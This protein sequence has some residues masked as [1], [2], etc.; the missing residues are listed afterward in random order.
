MT[1]QSKPN[2]VSLEHDS[3]EQNKHSLF[4]A[5]L[6]RAKYL[7]PNPVT[8][9]QVLHLEARGHRLELKEHDSSEPLLFRVNPVSSE[10]NSSERNKPSLF[11]A[12]FLQSNPSLFSAV[13]LQNKVSAATRGD[14]MANVAMCCVNLD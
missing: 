2:T 10:H 3:S 9:P 5:G 7:V 4:R 13:T 6:F 8:P 1:L 12:V 11:R 14:G